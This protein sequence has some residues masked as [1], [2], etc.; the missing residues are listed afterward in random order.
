MQIEQV[1]EHF[2]AMLSARLEAKVFTTE[3]SIRYTFYSAAALYGGVRHTEVV[4]EYPHPTMPDAR[5]DTF[6]LAN[7]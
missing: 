2:S 5:I 7:P 3:D 6:L 1:L 4:L